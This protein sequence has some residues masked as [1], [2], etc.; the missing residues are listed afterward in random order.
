MTDVKMFYCTYRRIRSGSAKDILVASAMVL[1]TS[2]EE[3][4]QKYEAEVSKY[5]FL[6]SKYRYCLDVS[7]S[8]TDV[9]SL[10]A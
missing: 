7:E 6:D 2:E 8:T 9:F 5:T 1:A 4:R 10:R 3:A